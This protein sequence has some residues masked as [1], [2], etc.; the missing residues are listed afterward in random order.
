MVTLFYVV[1]KINVNSVATGKIIFYVVSKIS[2]VSV[3][4]DEI[5]FHVNQHIQSSHQGV[6]FYEVLQSILVSVVS[7]KSESQK[8]MKSVMELLF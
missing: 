2:V 4:S 7:D 3:A 8:W 1:F 5:I 6:Y